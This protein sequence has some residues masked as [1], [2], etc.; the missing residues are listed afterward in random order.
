MPICCV[1]VTQIN[2]STVHDLRQLERQFRTVEV[3]AVILDLRSNFVQDLHHTLLLADALMDGGVIGRVHTGRKVREYRADRECLFRDWPLAVVVDR[4]TS[5]GG[6]WIAAA[7]QDNH[8]A[9]IVGEPT[10][11]IAHIRTSV[12]LPGNDGA[13]QMNTAIFERPS[14]RSLAKIMDS[15]PARPTPRPIAGEADQPSG[16]VIPD[17][18]KPPEAAPGFAT[19]SGEP[20][21]Q[22]PRRLQVA[23]VD[24][25]SML[26]IAVFELRARLDAGE[27]RSKR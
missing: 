16:G 17:L 25:S 24:E 10:A 23:R 4:A 21:R 14:G 22:I 2:G 9:V 18:P 11:G 12:L 8:M 3:Q 13:V 1:K 20:R 26:R 7:L 6:E 19:P 15:I 5:G 27:G